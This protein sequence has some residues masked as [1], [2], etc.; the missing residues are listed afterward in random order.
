M[1]D[2]PECKALCETDPENCT[3]NTYCEHELAAERL[4]RVHDQ[5]TRKNCTRILCPYCGFWSFKRGRSFCCDL[6]RHAVIAVLSGE[7]ALKTAEA[8]ERAMQN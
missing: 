3:C 4:M 2:L 1:C 6:L 8:A 7:R 5:I